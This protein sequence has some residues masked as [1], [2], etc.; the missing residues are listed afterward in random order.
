MICEIED[1]A[2]WT[3]GMRPHNMLLTVVL[4]GCG[5]LWLQNHRALNK[6]EKTMVERELQVSVDLHL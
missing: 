2:S 3:F 5:G 4:M 1:D 6:L